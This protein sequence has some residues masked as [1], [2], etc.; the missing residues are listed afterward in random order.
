M[1]DHENKLIIMVY[2]ADITT[3]KIIYKPK[4]GMTL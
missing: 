3:L 1:G 2:V 4:T